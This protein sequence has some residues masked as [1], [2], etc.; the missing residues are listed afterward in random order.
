MMRIGYLSDI[1]PKTS[2]TFVLNEITGL[3]R[4][5]EV[6]VF[7]LES[8]KVN[9]PEDLKVTYFKKRLVKD[10]ISSIKAGLEKELL[11]RSPKEHYFRMI[12]QYFSEHSEGQEILHRHFATNSIAYY[13]SKISDTPYTV[14]THAW[15]LFANDRY[16]HLDSVLKNAKKVITISEFNK[17]FIT[18]NFGLKEENIEVVR[19]GIDP[20][21]FTPRKTKGDIGKFLSVGRLVEKKGLEYAISAFG[22]I[23]RKYP[24]TEYTIVGS[25]PE[26]PKLRGKIKELK[27]EDKVQIKSNISNEDLVEE[28]KKAGTF[29]L[30]CI[31]AQ[32]GDMDGIPVVLMEAMAMEK[33][34]ISTTVSGI[35]ELIEHGRS[36]LLVK[37]KDVK[38]LAEALDMV[39]SQ[40]MEGD[41]L[42]K[43][44]RATVIKDFNI[45]HQVSSME[46]IFKEVLSGDN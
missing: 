36:G 12:A 41:S 43:E 20:N 24:D 28:Y 17:K 14:T 21:R 1:F 25:G 27:L 40:G 13:L 3:L 23:A 10:G 4:S 19:M 18:K 39:L 30:P 26:E 37:P 32:D 34:V 6:N 29:I 9:I 38:E 46:L 5:H 44:A 15:D 35:G 45:N 22:N 31:R 2:E 11:D 42:S 33:L 7:A 8:E 16:K